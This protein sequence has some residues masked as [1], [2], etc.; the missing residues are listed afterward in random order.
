MI[1]N[2]MHGEMD[3]IIRSEHSDPFHILGA[4]VVEV[5]PED[6]ATPQSVVVIRAF[7][8]E[9]R[10]A[11]IVP[12]GQTQVPVPM[13]K[14]RGEG[15]FEVVF[16]DRRQPFPYEI[17]L[18]DQEGKLSQFIDPY[19][20]PPVLTDFDLH[21]MGEGT[22]FK[23]YEKL[24]G[25]LHTIQGVSGVHFAVWAPNAARVS[26]IGDFNHWDGRR[27]PMRVRGNSGLWE[28]FIPGL[29][30][31]CIYK[32]EIKS[33]WNNSLTI[34]ADPYGAYFE[35]PPKTASIVHDT[36]R[37]VWQ[38]RDWMEKRPTRNWLDSPVSIYEVHLGSWMRATEENNRYLTYDE[39]ADRLI[40]YA[41]DLGYTHLQLLPVME[42][43]FDGSWGYQTIGYFAPTSRFGT[44]E[45]FKAFVDR[46]HQSGLGVLLDWV[47]AHFPKDAHGLSF[48][49]GTH[50]YEHADRR[51]GEHQDWGTLIFNYGRNEVRNFLLSNALF[52]LDQYHIDGLRVDAVA[53]MLYLD[54]SRQSGDWIPNMYGGHENL[55]AIEFIKRFNEVVHQ[56]HPGVL[57]I[58]EESTAWP[59]VSRP[60]YLGGLGFSMKWNMG[61]MNDVLS[62]FEKDPIYRKFHQN[63][64]T[65]ALMYAF[66]ENF[67][68]PLSH[69]EVVHMKRSLLDKM[70]GYFMEDKFSNLRLLYG[71]MYGH[72]GKKL[73][74]MGGEFGQWNE[75]NHDAGLD[76]NLLQWE[77]H[78]KL[79]KYVHDLNHL[80]LS[81]PSMYEVDFHYAGF[82]WIDFHD[83]DNSVVS[84]LRK[85]KNPA[86]FL[87]FI[88]NFTP[89]V[90]EHYQIGVP[91]PGMY[92]EIMNSDSAYY[93]GRNVGN[94]GAIQALEVSRGNWPCQLTLTLPPLAMLVLQ[95]RAS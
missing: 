67:I 88:Y 12:T 94:L 83:H 17:R 62:Y 52:W 46:C 51:L 3:K 4:H 21:L 30:E 75:W 76:W 25:H 69:D 31:G 60:V 6:G 34:K 49:D 78:Q 53:S 9:A 2:S 86:D 27:H 87:V 92:E 37:Y 20:F 29:E 43:P 95:R 57:T 10:E 91:G 58:A 77:S 93:G 71:Y 70:P 1:G 48:F 39:L 85:G 22:H 15:F 26:V 63:N 42:H 68:L 64:L 50:L 47:P 33:R 56:Y 44:P 5:M 79:Q 40:S 41:C 23:K 66:T 28:I 73:L 54:Y 74:F 16:P 8:P 7:L 13:P 80:Y 61:W 19:S 82:E 65:F 14:I 81:Q 18:A 36:S 72:P 24:G 55:E 84:F 11:W 59:M 45:Q 89:L 38:D 90:R 32:F 35:K